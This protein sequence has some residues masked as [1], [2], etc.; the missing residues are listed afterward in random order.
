MNLTK[1]DVKMRFAKMKH[2]LI[3]EFFQTHHI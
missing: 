3:V 1:M 2:E